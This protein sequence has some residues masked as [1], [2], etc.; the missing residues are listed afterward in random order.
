MGLANDI[1]NHLGCWLWS[2]LI[3]GIIRYDLLKRSKI[4]NRPFDFDTFVDTE[5]KKIAVDSSHGA[6]SRLI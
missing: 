2:S 3:P 5:N 6:L 4:Y 1:Y